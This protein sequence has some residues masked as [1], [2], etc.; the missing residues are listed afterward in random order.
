MTFFKKLLFLILTCIFFCNVAFGADKIVYLNVDKVMGL[1]KAGKY[2]KSQLDKIHKSNI[3]SFKKIEEKLKK[4]EKDLIA[5]KNILSKDDFQ[6]EINTLRSQANE[7]KQKRSK[8]IKDVN[9]KRVNASKKIIDL[10][11]PLLAKY[12]DENG[13]AIIISKKNIIMGQN[14]L[15]I[16]EDI[17]KLVDSEIKPFKLK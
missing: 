13:I 2:L 7:Y 8:D 3:E 14:Q 17:I 1:S 15:D 4:D 16:T 10:M 9:I 12:A 5:K 6:K 11:N